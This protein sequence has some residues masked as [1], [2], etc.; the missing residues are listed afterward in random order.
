[1]YSQEVVQFAEH[2]G[3]YGCVS[4]PPI[5]FTSNS[6]VLSELRRKADMREDFTAVQID[7]ICLSQSVWLAACMAVHAHHAAAQNCSTHT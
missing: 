3:T 5:T 2:W 1:M 7:K 6:T 4:L